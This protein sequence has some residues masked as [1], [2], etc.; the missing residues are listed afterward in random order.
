MGV[1]GEG[2]RNI[3]DAGSKV[4]TALDEKN[5]NVRFTSFGGSRVS[6]VI[7]VDEADYKEALKAVYSALK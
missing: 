1:V 7:G 4:F 5:I 2:I 3:A 6:L